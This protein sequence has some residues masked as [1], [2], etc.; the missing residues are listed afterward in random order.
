[1]GGMDWTASTMSMA[2]ETTTS[3]TMSASARATMGMDMDLPS[4]K[5]SM[6]WNWNTVGACF[7]SESWYITTPCMFA[8]S[9]VGIV[10]LVLCLEF[11]RR[12]AS[13]FDAF[14]TKRAKLRAQFLDNGNDRPSITVTDGPTRKAT[15]WTPSGSISALPPV[16][17][18]ALESEPTPTPESAPAPASASTTTPP[19]K[20]NQFIF[21]PSLT[22]QLI[23]AFLHM[24]QFAVAY[25]VILLAMYYNGYI[26]IC[27]FVGAFLGFFL[28]SWDNV[29]EKE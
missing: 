28:F 20:D 29:L 21:R 27:I 19:V 15:P 1:M 6:L 5:I 26:I 8:F 24:L 22:E 7:I 3:A 9:C 16:P 23:R 4:C 17:E 25:F 13:E 18:S 10:C 11:L 12:V 2:T 14:I